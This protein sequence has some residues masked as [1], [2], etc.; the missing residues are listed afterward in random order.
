MFKTPEEMLEEIHKGI[1][2]YNPESGEYIFEYNDLGAI[3][4]SHIDPEEAK[5]L[6][7]DERWDDCLCLD[8]EIY[9]PEGFDP[10]GGY[11]NTDFCKW[12]YQ[13]NW[14]DTRHYREEVLA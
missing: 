13:E 7:S 10:L 8:G 12:S 4:L 2:F 14:I 9:D 3:C 5:D 6:P 1:D 11:T